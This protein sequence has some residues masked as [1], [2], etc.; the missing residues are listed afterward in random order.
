MILAEKVIDKQSEFGGEK[1]VF[2]LFQKYDLEKEIETIKHLIRGTKPT[3]NPPKYFLYQVSIF[4]GG[5]I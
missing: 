3:S 1:S 5:M 2:E 4:L